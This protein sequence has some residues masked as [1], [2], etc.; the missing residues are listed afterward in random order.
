MPYEVEDKGE[1]SHPRIC[2]T[3]LDPGI[4]EQKEIRDGREINLDRYVRPQRAPSEHQH[5]VI[6]LEHLAYPLPCQLSFLCDDCT[7]LSAEHHHYRLHW[8]PRY[9]L[10]CHPLHSYLLHHC[11]HRYHSPLC[12]QAAGPEREAVHSYCPELQLRHE[13]SKMNV[14]QKRE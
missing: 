10:H 9:L 5:Q 8:F 13:Q 7:C 11:R 6:I 1:E 3:L 4:D 12:V 2:E 14:T